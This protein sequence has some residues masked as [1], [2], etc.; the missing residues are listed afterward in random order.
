MAEMESQHVRY[1]TARVACL[2]LTVATCT[3]L[4]QGGPACMQSH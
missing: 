1:G 4:L 2:T 3:D